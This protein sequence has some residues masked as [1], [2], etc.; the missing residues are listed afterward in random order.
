[1]ALY[2]TTI[3]QTWPDPNPTASSLRIK[4]CASRS[5]FSFHGITVIFLKFEGNCLNSYLSAFFFSSALWIRSKAHSLIFW[6]P[7]SI[8]YA[9]KLRSRLMSGFLLDLSY[10]SMMR[11]LSFVGRVFFVAIFIQSA[12]T[13]WAF[14]CFLVSFHWRWWGC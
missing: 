1:M 11:F 4:H 7:R 5:Y 2:L 10:T 6:N 8:S 13:E 14:L 9:F 12:Y 3:Y